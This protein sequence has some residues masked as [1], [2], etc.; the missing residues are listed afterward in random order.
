MNRVA[1]TDGAC[2]RGFGGWAVVFDDQEL[3]DVFFCAFSKSGN[4]TISVSTAGKLPFMARK[5]REDLDSYIQ[6]KEIWLDILEPF[7][8]RLESIDEKNRVL[9][10]MYADQS[11]KELVGKGDI[12]GA[13]KRAEEVFD[14]HSQ[15]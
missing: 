3:S 14:V 2:S 12:E 10:Q 5:I 11:L 15:R 9:E 1:Y 6:G 8:N 13:R 7:R 4:I